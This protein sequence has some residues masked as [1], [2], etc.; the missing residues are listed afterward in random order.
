LGV[1]FNLPVIGLDGIRIKPEVLDVV[2]ESV[3][4]RFNIIPLFQIDKEL[5]VATSDP[6]DIQT[7]DIISSQAKCKVTPVLA[8]Y[9]EIAK[10]IEK[11]YS[12]K[13]ESQ[14][15]ENIKN[16][17][18]TKISSLELQELR[19]AGVDLPIVKIV[20]RILIDAVEDL[21]SDVHI[22][23]R[24]NNLIV[25]LRID[26]L[27]QEYATYP[28]NMHPGIVSRSKILATL[29]ISERQKPQ[30]GKIQVKIDNNEI[31][32][33]VSTMPTIYGEKVVMRLLNRANVKV[34]IEDLGFTENNHSIFQEFIREPYGIILVTGPTGS[35]KTTT[36]YAALNK[37]NSVWKNIVTVEDPVEYQLQ[38]INQ[39]QINPKKDLTFATALKYILRQDP[40]VIMI[41]EIRDTETASM[42]AEAALTGHLVFSTLH[43]N[44]AL[45]TITRLIDMGVEPFLLAPSLIGIIA[46]RLVRTICPSCKEEYTPSPA[47]LNTVGL[48]FSDEKP[49]FYKGKGCNQCRYTGYKG[50]TAIHEILTINGK[51]RNLIT[52]RASVAAMLEE[53]VRC[54]FKD[55]RFNGLKKVIS[56]ITTVEELLRITMKAR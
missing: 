47:E 53:A 30:D 44:D 52:N 7:L 43:T 26:G 1:Q 15:A 46:Q 34:S 10:T 11:Y 9:S 2:S 25:R 5:T 50:R 33:R 16:T 20:D 14:I 4:K 8:S 38:G 48:A 6:T 54:G 35:G 27:L 12:K 18:T 17:E 55:L 45:T 49:Y 36:L 29:D 32:I 23:P 19:K 56:G 39:I 40:D 51:I 24:E 21:A 42:A 3:A 28:V 13:I 41:G 22:E 37:I 31:D